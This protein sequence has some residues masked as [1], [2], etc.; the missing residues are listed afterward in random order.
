MMDKMQYYKAMADGTVAHPPIADLI[1]FKVIEADKGKIVIELVCN[2]KMVNS[3]GAVQGG[4]TAT[5][6][7]ASMGMAAMT[8][9]DDTHHAITVELKINFLRQP[10]MERLISTG[11]I[12]HPGRKV[13]MGEAEVV[14]EKG[15]LVAKA[16][17][18]LMILEEGP[19]D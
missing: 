13:M 3:I 11:R 17:S 14:S 1:G 16:T 12:V 6:A 15:K 4:I 18:T 8:L 2:E 10:G 7:D 5:I 19:V 9:M